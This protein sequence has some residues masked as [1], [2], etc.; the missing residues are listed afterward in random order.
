MYLSGA[1][2]KQARNTYAKEVYKGSVCTTILIFKQGE[3]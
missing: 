2:R 3:W 1:I